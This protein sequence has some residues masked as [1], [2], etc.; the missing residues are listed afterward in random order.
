MS[1]QN[2][3]ADR[4]EMIAQIKDRL[5]IGEDR[6]HAAMGIFDTPEELVEAGAKIKAMG[7]TKIDA[8]S[9]FPVHG[10]DPAIGIPPSKLGWVSVTFAILGLLTA[11]AL[12]YYVGVINYPL[13]IAGKP[14]FDFTFTIPVTFELT[15]LFT[16][17]STFV[18]MWAI[19][20]LPQLYH[21]T[22]NYKNAHRATDDGFIL[23]VE[24]KD[25]MFEPLKT[26]EHLRSVGAAEVEVVEG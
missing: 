16:G 12:M 18:G 23:I 2:L 3:P 17:I 8:M 15:I 26:A 13:N 11:Q 19:N 4:L 21:A 20:G 9:P 10:I 6:V 7:Y 1:S 5:G 24:A 14:L 25:P 22:F